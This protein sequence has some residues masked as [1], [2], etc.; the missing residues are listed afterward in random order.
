MYRGGR[1]FVVRWGRYPRLR[2]RKALCRRRPDV[3]CAC[4]TRR[5]SGQGAMS[6]RAPGRAFSGLQRAVDD[7]ARCGNAPCSARCV[8]RGSTDSLQRYRARRRP[9]ETVLTRAPGPTLCRMSGGTRPSPLQQVALSHHRARRCG[10][11][12]RPTWIR[13]FPSPLSGAGCRSCPKSAIRLS[14]STHA[15]D[16]GVARRPGL[17]LCSRSFSA[18]AGRRHRRGNDPTRTSE[19][20][21]IGVRAARYG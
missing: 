9:D 19:R 3:L 2:R 14:G 6:K 5:P 1:A 10:R 21:R 7:R 11:H 12:H 20:R 13:P 4:R 8:R 15:T 18:R 16:F 17:R